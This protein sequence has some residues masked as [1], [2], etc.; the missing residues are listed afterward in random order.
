M[1]ILAVSEDGGANAKPLQMV[2]LTF[3]W[4][5]LFYPFHSPKICRDEAFPKQLINFKT[6]SIWECFAQNLRKSLADPKP[7]GQFIGYSEEGLA[8]ADGDFDGKRRCW[9]KCSTPTNG[10]FD[11]WMVVFILSIPLI[12]NS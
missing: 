3:R 8:F 12:K 4:L 2:Y 5:C 9:R 6:I 1:K 11:V 7:Q 10:M